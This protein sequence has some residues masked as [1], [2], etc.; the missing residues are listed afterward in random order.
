MIWVNLLP[1][2]ERQRAARL[3]N[4]G[5]VLLAMMLTGGAL[6]VVLYLQLAADN[7]HWRQQIEQRQRALTVADSLA[8]QLAE[9]QLQHQG[10]LERQQRQQRQQQL[11]QRWQQ[12]VHSLPQLLPEYLWLTSFVQAPSGVQ[13]SGISQQLND[14]DRLRQ[15]LLTQ[16]LLQQVSTGNIERL[17]DGGLQFSIRAALQ[18][19]NSDE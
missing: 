14:V 1:W 13:I 12:F 8:Q 9:A 18:E 4:D 2:R 6:L 19:G 17:P 7:R 3:R 11:N 16:P 5:I 10:L 15:Q